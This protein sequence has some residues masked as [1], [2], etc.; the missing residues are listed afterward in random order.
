MELL[1][2][3]LRRVKEGGFI[4]D[5]K[6][7]DSGLFISHLSSGDDTILF[8]DADPLQLMHIRMV[9]TF[10]EELNGPQVNMSMSYV[11]I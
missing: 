7:A 11:I 9:L 6:V 1:N 2:G 3:M 8:C 10:F 4:K 5:F